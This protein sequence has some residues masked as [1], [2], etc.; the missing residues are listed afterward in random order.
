VPEL[1]KRGVGVPL[2]VIGAIIVVVLLHL[3]LGALGKLVP[4][5]CRECGEASRYH[6]FGWWPFKYRYTCT[7]CRHTMGFEVG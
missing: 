5:R 2:L 3:L 6:G 4:V 7:R 1:R